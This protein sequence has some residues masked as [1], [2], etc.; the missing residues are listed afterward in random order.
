MA[1]KEITLAH[2]R[3]GIAQCPG[4]YLEADGEYLR[5]IGEAVEIGELRDRV[6]FGEAVVR[7]KRE[8]FSNL[9]GPLSRTLMRIGL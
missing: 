2:L 5:I 7:I 8:Y 1:L 9:G 6:G 4:V 3:C